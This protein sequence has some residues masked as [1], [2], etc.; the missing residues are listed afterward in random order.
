MYNINK[1]TCR[2]SKGGARIILSKTKKDSK[3]KDMEIKAFDKKIWQ[4]SYYDHVI[5]GEQDYKE[6]WEY[7]EN[8]PKQWEEDEFY[9][10]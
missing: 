2:G 10:K 5:R 7:I 1:R 4:K 9:T 8:N 6:I 3:E